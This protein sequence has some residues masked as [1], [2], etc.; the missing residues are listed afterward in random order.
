MISAFQRRGNTYELFDAACFGTDVM[1]VF[2]HA[3]KSQGPTVC[4]GDSG[5]GYVFKDR[6]G[7]HGRYY[8][9]VRKISKNYI[10]T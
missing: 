5:G 4:H 3:T 2:L 6:Y 10:H 8:V 9:Q 7:I 1:I